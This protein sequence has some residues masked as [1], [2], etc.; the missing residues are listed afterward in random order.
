[1]YRGQD[2]GD[3]QQLESKCLSILLEGSVE[4]LYDIL[5]HLSVIRSRSFRQPVEKL[6]ESSNRDKKQFAVIALG[7]LGG[8]SSL[9]HLSRLARKIKDWQGPGIRSLERTLIAAL[10]ESGSPASIPPLLE[11]FRFKRRHRDLFAAERRLAVITALATLVQQGV[12]EAQEKLL[13]LLRHS[14]PDLRAQAATELGFAFWHQ[15]PQVPEKI[16]EALSICLK[17]RVRAVQQAA[18]ISLEDLATLGND[19]ARDLL[20]GR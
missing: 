16:L 10:G 2:I 3:L 8:E 20:G 11:I 1:M 6:L 12:E 13:E 15:A 18:R 19:T 7:I 9:S 5:P 17:D 14:S 4:A